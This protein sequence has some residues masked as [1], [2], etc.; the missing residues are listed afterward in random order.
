M[1]VTEYIL[2]A[3][4]DQGVDHCF[5]DLGGVVDNFMPPLTGTTGLRTIVAAFEGGAAYMA[6]GYARASGGLGVCLGMGGPGVLNMVT[7][8]AGARADRSPVIAISGEVAHLSD[9]MAGL[10][11]AYGAGIDDIEVLRRIT[12]LSLSVSSPAVAPHHLRHAITHAFAHRS[13]VHLS[14]PVDVQQAEIGTGWRPVPD[15]PAHRRDRS[16]LCG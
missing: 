7:A 14:V 3:L 12:G 13:P 15:A 4:R 6:D 5:I 11:D 16:Q 1:L 8:L 2:A 10:Q 9:G